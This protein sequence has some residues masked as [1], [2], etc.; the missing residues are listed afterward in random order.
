VDRDQRLAGENQRG[1]TAGGILAQR[2]ERQQAGY[3]YETEFRFGLD[4]ILD[5]LE[6][7]RTGG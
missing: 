7:F 3:D 2:E 1:V 6:R 4:L 5:G